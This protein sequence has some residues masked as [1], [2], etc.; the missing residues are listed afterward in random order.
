MS[1]PNASARQDQQTVL[2]QKLAD[3]FYNREY[4]LSATIHD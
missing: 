2:R 3:F 1:S 4:R